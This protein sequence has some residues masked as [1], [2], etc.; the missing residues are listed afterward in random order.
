M[1]DHNRILLL[2][3]LDG[4]IVVVSG[5]FTPYDQVYPHCQ[6]VNGTTCCSDFQHCGCC[7]NYRCYSGGCYTDKQIKDL[8]REITRNSIIFLITLGCVPVMFIGI[9]LFIIGLSWLSNRSKIPASIGAGS[10]P[11]VTSSIGSDD[12]T[13]TSEGSEED[14][15]L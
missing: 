4:F 2:L 8:K 6:S 7:I 12:P 15:L 9:I 3:I 5:Q 13:T 14:A 1:N 10:T 11:S